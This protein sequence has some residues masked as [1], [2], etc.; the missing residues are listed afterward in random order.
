MLVTLRDQR[1]KEQ[2]GKGTRVCGLK[3]LQYPV[4]KYLDS[5]IFK[6]KANN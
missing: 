2:I 6:N 4:S 1:V 3:R 5:A